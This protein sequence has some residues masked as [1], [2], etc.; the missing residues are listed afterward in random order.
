[1][2][3]KGEGSLRP[4][5]EVDEERV[6]PYAEPGQCSTVKHDSTGTEH[7]LARVYSNL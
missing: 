2:A 6:R 7:I 5:T 4:P 3:L 1:M